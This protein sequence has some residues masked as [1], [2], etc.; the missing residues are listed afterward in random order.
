MIEKYDY[1]LFDWD[2]CLAKT[3]EVWLYAHKTAYIEFGANPTDQE[4]ISHFGNWQA[5]ALFG[6][7][8]VNGCVARTIELVNEQLRQVELYTG[9]AELL[10]YLKSKQKKL[11]LLS[12]SHKEAL[13]WGIEHNKLEGIFDFILSADDVMQHKPHPEI[14]EKALAQFGVDGTKAIMIGDSSKDIEA[15][16][17]A[18]I[19]S[20]LMYPKSHELFYD[21]EKLKSYK[22]TFI[23]SGF[24]EFNE[25]L[26]K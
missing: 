6:I 3:L 8:D 4:V 1:F 14:I 10:R 11:A 19:A 9:A 18:G 7:A 21:L 20:A 25:E 12:S 23:F 16:N 17:N 2:G 5:A 24:A 13:R 22:P 26:E 15:A